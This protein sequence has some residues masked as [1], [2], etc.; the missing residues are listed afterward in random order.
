MRRRYL[1]ADLARDLGISPG[2]VSQLVAQGMPTHSVTAAREWRRQ[3][4]QPQWSKRPAPG[5]TAAMGEQPA[6]VSHGYEPGDLVAVA[7]ELAGVDI[8]AGLHVELGIP[9]ERA[10]VAHSVIA[11]A[12]DDALERLGYPND[13]V[14]VRSPLCKVRPDDDVS[15]EQTRIEARVAQLRAEFAAA[16]DVLEAPEAQ[17]SV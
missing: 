14:F 1:K 3:H 17:S 6:P 10:R 8:L 11:C 16:D 5:I 4:L 9:L 7:L 13:V 12:L 15:E 2:R